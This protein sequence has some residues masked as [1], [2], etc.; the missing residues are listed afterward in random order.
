M[1]GLS[2]SF[3]LFSI[4]HVVEANSD[5]VLLLSCYS[6]SFPT[7]LGL[8]PLLHKHCTIFYQCL[9]IYL[10]DYSQPPWK[11]WLYTTHPHG[12]LLVGNNHNCVC[13]MNDMLLMYDFHSWDTFNF[14]K[15]LQVFSQPLITTL[16]S[17]KQEFSLC[18]SCILSKEFSLFI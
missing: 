17:S 13:W 15:I 6:V 14:S 3:R 4:F 10:P 9:S 12:A 8:D 18:F 16:P 5:L 11:Q 1:K 2:Y 7:S